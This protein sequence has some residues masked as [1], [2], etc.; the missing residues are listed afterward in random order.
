MLSQDQW[1]K[2]F[3]DAKKIGEYF[4]A[5]PTASNKEIAEALKLT[6]SSVQRFLGAC[7]NIETGTTYTFIMRELFTQEQIVQIAMQIQINILKSRQKGGL[8]SQQN[9]DYIKDE[10]GKFQGSQRH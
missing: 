9:N 4:L 1:N 6:P 3:E 8:I 10:N 2:M 7:T 5:N